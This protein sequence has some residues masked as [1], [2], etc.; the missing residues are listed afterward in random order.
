M[1][2]VSCNDFMYTQ[3]CLVVR[4]CGLWETLRILQRYTYELWERGTGNGNGEQGTGRSTPTS[5]QGTHD[6]PH[7]DPVV[8][9]DLYSSLP[10][11]TPVDP[12][13]EPSRARTTPGSDGEFRHPLV[14]PMEEISRNP[15]CHGPVWNSGTD[16]QTATTWAVVCRVSMRIK[17]V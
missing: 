9:V 14:A 2:P 13:R 5:F 11:P 16:G 12:P 8:V 15:A 3:G 4:G 7:T 1:L 10:C 17:V 6:I